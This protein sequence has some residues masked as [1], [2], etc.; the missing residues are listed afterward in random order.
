VGERQGNKRLGKGIE[1]LF[2][3]NSE[4]N[5]VDMVNDIEKTDNYQIR[6]ISLQKL[7][8]NPYQP[9]KEFDQAALEELAQ[10]VKEHGVIQPI[11]VRES[12]FGYDI[13]AGERR[14][15]AAKL[16]GLEHIPAVI[17][18]FSDDAMMQLAILE[19]IQRE[20]LN[21]LEEANGYQSLLNKFGWTQQQLA[22]RMGKSRSHI[23]NILRLLE[24]PQSVQQLLSN[25]KITM[26]HAKVLLG[27]SE[28]KI[29]MIMSEVLA[30]GLSVRET[31]RLAKLE[32]VEPNK[33]QKREKPALSTDAEIQRMFVE[34]QLIAYLG[35]KVVLDDKKL[36]INFYDTAELN[37]ILQKI[38]LT[39]KDEE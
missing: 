3:A 1:A 36:I 9:R 33:E 18:S 5:L 32:K 22:E 13:L 14:F 35:T 2:S 21:I 15:R 29:D 28:Q 39:R 11:V 26:G 10:S 12:S 34:E 27:L 24:L 37:A 8:A 19:N 17:K 7:R 20:D 38:G 25:D 16:A 23:T 30:K 31:E 6:E 4:M